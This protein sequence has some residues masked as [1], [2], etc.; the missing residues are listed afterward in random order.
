MGLKRDVST[1]LEIR[2]QKPQKSDY[3][4]DECL[5]VILKA[6]KRK[7]YMSKDISLRSARDVKY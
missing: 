6:K 3:R 1:I 5:K 2:G 7:T 4:N